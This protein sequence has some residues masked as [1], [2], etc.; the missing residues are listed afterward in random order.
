MQSGSII[1]WEIDGKKVETVANFIFLGC[2]IA[3]DD[4]CTPE[5]NTFGRKVMTNLVCVCLVTHSCWTLCDP[6]DCSPPD[7]SV[8]GNRR[9]KYANMKILWKV[10]ILFSRAPKSLQTVTAAMKLGRKTLT[11][12]DNIVKCRDITLTTKVCI[13]KGTVFSSNNVQIWD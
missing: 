1:S 4:E 7:S 13:V 9:G 11:N 6:L 12:L 8:H 3:V 10:N 5:M 2:K